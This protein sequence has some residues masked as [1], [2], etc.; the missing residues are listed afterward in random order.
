MGQFDNQPTT[1][2]AAD[3]A[4]RQAAIATAFF[5]GIGNLFRGV[6]DEWNRV[7][8]PASAGVNIG[9]DPYGQ[10][11]VQGRAGGTSAQPAA[12][13]TVTMSPIL[14]LA[15]GFIAYQYMKGR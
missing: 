11:Y 14:M 7:E 12:R 1:L 4:T 3:D 6:D 2:V 9:F 10:V 13:A 8:V 5:Y 15:L